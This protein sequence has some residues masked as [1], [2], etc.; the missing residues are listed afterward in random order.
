[1]KLF[2]NSNFLFVFRNIYNWAISCLKAFPNRKAQ[3]LIWLIETNIESLGYLKHKGANILIIDYDKLC[4]HPM[5]ICENLF[6]FLNIKEDLTQ[7]KCLR[8]DSQ[9]RRNLSKDI[10]SLKKI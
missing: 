6:K 4:L 10:T 8:E 2:P 3:D 9:K 5:Q 7:P 1:H